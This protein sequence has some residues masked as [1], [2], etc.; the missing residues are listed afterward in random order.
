MTSVRRV[1]VPN[2]KRHF[3]DPSASAHTAAKR[4]WRLQLDQKSHPYMYSAYAYTQSIELMF[5]SLGSYVL[6][7]LSLSRQ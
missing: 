1:C 4:D 7:I 5:T 2:Y 3:A 6:N